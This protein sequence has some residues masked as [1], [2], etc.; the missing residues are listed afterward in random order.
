[1]L[2][3]STLNY[4]G[5]NCRD[6]TL[7]IVYNARLVAKPVFIDHIHA[8]VQ[9]LARNA[10][11]SSLSLFLF[12]S[13]ALFLCPAAALVPAGVRAIRRQAE[14]HHALLLSLSLLVFVFVFVLLL[15]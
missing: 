8:N 10:V 2:G 9:L 7:T 12:L 14:A 15:L 13:L 4:F 11:T 3:Q 5:A 1:M 6:D